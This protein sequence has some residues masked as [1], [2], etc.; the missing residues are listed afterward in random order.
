MV[1]SR[2]KGVMPKIISPNQCSFVPGRQGADNIIVAQEIIHSMRNKKGKQGFMAIKI[3]LE[4]AYDRVKW[5]FLL[6][7][8]HELKLTANIIK[9]NE[10]Y[11][12]TASMQVLWNGEKGEHFNPSRGLRQGD[13]L[14]PYLFVLIMEKFAHMI[15]TEVKEENWKPF[16]LKKKDTCL[17]QSHLFFTDDLFLF[18]EADMD[19][20]AIVRACL[21]DFC[22]AS[23][24]K[25]NNL[26]SRVFLSK[27]VNHT[28]V[29]EISNF[30]GFTPCADLGKYLGV[31]LHHQ[32]VTRSTHDYIL[33]KMDKRLSAWKANALSSAARHTLVQSVLSAIPSYEM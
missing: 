29:T 3:D 22:A 13:P 10:W 16:R 19:Q 6:R 1:A 33:G 31:P 26:N 5:P 32:R 21:D 9:I 7:C 30:M 15:Q 17:S 12:S 23:G 20:A 2:L 8:R 25:V 27:N 28:C 4:K 24:E 14:S 11:I 18:A